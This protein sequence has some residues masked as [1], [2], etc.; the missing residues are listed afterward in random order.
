MILDLDLNRFFATGSFRLIWVVA[1]LRKKKVTPWRAI[2][3][4]S[5]R[6]GLNIKSLV[7]NLHQ[8]GRFLE[9][10]AESWSKVCVRKRGEGGGGERM[11]ELTNRQPSYL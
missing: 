9:I 4:L 11:D 5:W 7:I 2:Q 8:L 6:W 3:R 1:L 10:L